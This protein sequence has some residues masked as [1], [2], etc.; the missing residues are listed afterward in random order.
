MQL[1]ELNLNNKIMK[2]L[3]QFITYISIKLYGNRQTI[4]KFQ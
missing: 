1:N 3:E 4:W 2:K